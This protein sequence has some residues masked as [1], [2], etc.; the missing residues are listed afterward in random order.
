[1]DELDPMVLLQAY[2]QGIFPMATE[3]DSIISWHRPSIR[4]IIPLERVYISGTLRKLLLSN[5]FHATLNT[6][7]A[8]VIAGCA[9]REQ[10]WISGDIRRA[11]TRLHQLGH[12]HSI[13]VWQGDILAGG[14]YGVAIN[15]AFF[16]E[17]MFHTI[18]DASK[19]AL[20]YLVHHMIARGM[21]LLDTQYI[22]DH[23][24]SMGAIEVSDTIF[25]GLLHKALH[26]NVS[27]IPS[28]KSGGLLELQ[29]ELLYHD[30]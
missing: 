21:I 1:M 15:G 4:G 11:Y 6:A 5:K 10:T 8:E 20:I 26:Q 27:F 16:G 30:T 7:F 29:P 17:S 13:E 12:A 2:R 24:R 14:L 3:E 22:N 25:R 18:R 9:S 23:I 19:V 28:G